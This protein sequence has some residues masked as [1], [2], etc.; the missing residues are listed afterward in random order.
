VSRTAASWQML[1]H[2]IFSVPWN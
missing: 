2:S 1:Q